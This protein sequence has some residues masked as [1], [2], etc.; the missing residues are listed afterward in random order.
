MHPS[1]GCPDRRI[2]HHVELQQH[3]LCLSHIT[4]VLKGS[5]L[6]GGCQNKSSSMSLSLIRILH[7]RKAHTERS[8]LHFTFKTT[9]LRPPSHS[10]TQVLTQGH[11]ISPEAGSSP[12][13]LTAVA[14]WLINHSTL[15]KHRAAAQ[16][17]H[18]CSARTRSPVF[19][20]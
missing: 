15:S 10:G 5:L 8:S 13:A 11:P 18:C 3:P 6:S 14:Y 17:A 12:R 16:T 1:P 9:T 20:C 19:S 4:Q 7:K 2:L